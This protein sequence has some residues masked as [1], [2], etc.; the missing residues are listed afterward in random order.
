MTENEEELFHTLLSDAAPE[1]ADKGFSAGITRQIKRDLWVRKIV[2]GLATI[3][4]GVVGITLL[5]GLSV[6]LSK[7][8]MSAELMAVPGKLSDPAWLA[9]NES[10][11]LTVLLMVGSPILIRFFA[12]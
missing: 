7:E 3:V 6:D 10:L 12:R 9:A 11:L 5:W 4:A 8:L 2:L 1:L